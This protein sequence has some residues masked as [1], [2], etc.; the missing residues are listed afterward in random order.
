[1]WK[2]GDMERQE[3]EGCPCDFSMCSERKTSKFGPSEILEHLREK[4]KNQ[5]DLY[6]CIALHY[7][8]EFLKNFHGPGIGHTRLYKMDSK[9]YETAMEK[10]N[11]AIQS[12]IERLDKE[13]ERLLH[14]FP[15]SRDCVG[16]TSP[17]GCIGS[18]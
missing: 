7:V 9:E 3:D 12:Y 18:T 14:W 16:S 11:T 15:S 13:K 1:M 8:E 10:E 17:P 4:S 5:I 6:H 2:K